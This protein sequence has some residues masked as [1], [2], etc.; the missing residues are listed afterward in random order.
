[1]KC[2][3]CSIARLLCHQVYSIGNHELLMALKSKIPMTGVSVVE[4]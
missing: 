3:M 1:M 4:G 2:I